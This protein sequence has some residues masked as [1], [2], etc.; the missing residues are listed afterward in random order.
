MYLSGTDQGVSS[1]SRGS[2]VDLVEIGGSRDKGWI[3]EVR[4]DRMCTPNVELLSFQNT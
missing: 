4:I 2:G 1:G 3:Q